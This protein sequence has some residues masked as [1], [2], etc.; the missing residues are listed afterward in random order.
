M[1]ELNII[2]VLDINEDY[3]NITIKKYIPFIIKQNIIDNILDACVYINEDNGF[4][5]V[6]SSMKRMAIEFSICN[7]VSNIDM[8]DED[9]LELYDK[10]KELGVIT[11]IISNIDKSE[12]DFITDCVNEK[13]EE[14]YKVDNSFQ[15]VVSQGLNKLLAKIPDN[16]GLTKFIKDL[17]KQ[18]DKLDPDK[19]K[20]VKDVIAYDK[21]DGK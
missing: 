18:F 15:S 7:Q 21:E 16:K 10:L 11:Y 1:Q 4:K 5:C 8:E 9:S 14:I 17:T 20:F 2:T 13:I 12:I 19:L 3:S 6:D